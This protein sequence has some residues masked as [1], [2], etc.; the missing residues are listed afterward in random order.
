MNELIL[1]HYWESPYAEKIRRV[2]GMKKL[3]WRSVIIPMM[4]PKPDLTA[5]TGGYRKTPVLQIGADIWCDSDLIACE[6]DRLHPDP[7]LF[8]DNSLPAAMML[9]SWQQELFFAA[10]RTVGMSAPVFPPGFLKDRA[11]MVDVPLT[12]ERA[13]ADAPALLQQL[14]AKL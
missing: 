1:H 10:V 8:P 11:G 12:M 9:G 14:R 4:M 5:L 3:A 13:I 2:M 7:P 6:I